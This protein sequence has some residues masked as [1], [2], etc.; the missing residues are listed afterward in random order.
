MWSSSSGYS[1]LF[2]SGTELQESQSPTT[3]PMPS[4]LLFNTPDVDPL[5]LNAGISEEKDAADLVDPYTNEEEVSYLNLTDFDEQSCN[6]GRL[7]VPSPFDESA[8]PELRS[9]STTSEEDS[10]RS[11]PSVNESASV[12]SSS[13]ST[14][15]PFK[16]KK[17]PRT[18]AEV[19]KFFRVKQEEAI[20][21]QHML[22]EEI[23]T[24]LSD[25]RITDAIPGWYD[26]VLRKLYEAFP[27]I[28]RWESGAETMPAQLDFSRY[29]CLL[30][31]VIIHYFRYLLAKRNDKMAERLWSICTPLRE[32][33][34]TG[35]AEL[36][37]GNEIRRYC[38]HLRDVI[39]D[40]ELAVRA[41]AQDIVNELKLRHDNTIFSWMTGHPIQL[42]LNNE[43]DI[44]VIPLSQAVSIFMH[45][46][47]L[48]DDMLLKTIFEFHA[49]I[50]RWIRGE[51]SMRLGGSKDFV[52]IQPDQLTQLF[53]IAV[54]YNADTSILS[55]LWYNNPDMQTAILNLPVESQAELLQKALIVN[56]GLPPLFV[57][58][59]INTIDSIP[60]LI[61][62]NDGLLERNKNLHG[63]ALALEQA[64]VQWVAGRILLLQTAE[65]NRVLSLDEKSPVASVFTP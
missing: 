20:P 57:V 62:V 16:K 17:R 38:L 11:T 27:E 21:F 4:G 7:P 40:F 35:F 49:D 65:R 42:T 25:V 26:A 10:L 50:K 29:S 43:D 32:L 9:D 60:C 31:P 15:S 44:D 46:F 3:S 61:K 30:S 52:M 1:P 2:G 5:D 48:H 12:A 54:T 8:M 34:T 59:W 13:A 47:L 45:A 58:C 41:G 63:S 24:Q 22:S 51:I 28:E 37:E 56:K 14:V 53:D 39:I 23:V 6:I 36:K 55:E 64:K 33:Y 18:S 19:V